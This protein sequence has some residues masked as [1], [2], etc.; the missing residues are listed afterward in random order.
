MS[1]SDNKKR[2]PPRSFLCCL[3]SDHFLRSVCFQFIFPH[4]INLQPIF[5]AHEDSK[6][7]YYPRGVFLQSCQ[8]KSRRAGRSGKSAKAAYDGERKPLVPCT[9]RTIICEQNAN[10]LCIETFFILPQTVKIEIGENSPISIFSSTVD[11]L[12][13]F[14]GKIAELGDMMLPFLIPSQK[15]PSLA[16]DH[17]SGCNVAYLASQ[18][19]LIA[20]KELNPHQEYLFPQNSETLESAKNL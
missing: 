16:T 18:H 19:N 13:C 17:F 10:K 8:G 6:N 14:A 1:H 5:N 20:N 3:L 15:N 12:Y 11:P 4:K 2:A 9:R 7:H